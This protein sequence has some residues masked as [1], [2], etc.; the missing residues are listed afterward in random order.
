M[1]MME[2]LSKIQQLNQAIVRTSDICA[3]LKV[4]KS[5]ASK[6]LSRLAATNQ[7]TR[8]SWGLWGFADK[9][10]L[11][12]LPEYLTAPY[13]SYVSLQTALYQRGMISQIPEVIYAVSP[14]RTKVFNTPLAT[15]S[16]H[17]IHPSFYFGFET[18][19]KK[20]IKLATPEKALLDV[21]YLKP[22]KSKL[23]RAL[24]EVEL[25]KTFDVKKARLMINHLTQKKQQT[26][27]QN[28]FSDFMSHAN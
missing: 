21:L 23:F 19:G 20:Q 22:A 1:R 9:I 11:L 25:P 10:D 27:L 15:V 28:A 6:L 14:H 8:I 12:M 17:H 24:P 7:I 4:N 3:C 2:A 16:I 18:I 5:H 13:P 26:R